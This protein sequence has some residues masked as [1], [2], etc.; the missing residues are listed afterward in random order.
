MDWARSGIRRRDVANADSQLTVKEIVQGSFRQPPV[1]SVRTVF[2]GLLTG[3]VA[4]AGEG[5]TWLGGV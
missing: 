2:V 3:G 4:G 1:S 5:G